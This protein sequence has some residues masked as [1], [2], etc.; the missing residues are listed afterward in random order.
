[1]LVKSGLASKAGGL[2]IADKLRLENPDFD[3][4]SGEVFGERDLASAGRDEA[5]QE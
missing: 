5:F 1:M 2:S 4:L 3:L